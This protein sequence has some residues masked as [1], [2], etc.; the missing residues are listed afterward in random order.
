MIL[1]EQ[2]RLQDYKDSMACIATALGLS[3]GRTFL[4]N[5]KPG[6]VGREGIAVEAIALWRR[7]NRII[8]RDCARG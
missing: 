2:P 7:E 1:A 4:S 3:L 6:F 8:I 5:E